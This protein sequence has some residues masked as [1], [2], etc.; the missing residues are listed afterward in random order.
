MH[1]G[2]SLS[3][4]FETI[5]YL[6]KASTASG[7]LFHVVNAVFFPLIATQVIISQS[8]NAFGQDA[9]ANKHF[10]SFDFL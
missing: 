7:L 1:P 2:L 8:V 4:L 3:K 10:V 6:G 9:R 5:P